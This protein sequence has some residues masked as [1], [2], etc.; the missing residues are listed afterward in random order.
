MTLHATEPIAK[1]GWTYLAILGGV[2]LFA[3]WADLWDVIVFALIIALGFSFYVFRNP[4][5]ILSEDDVL[6]IIAPIDGKVME[7]E[8][9]E[10]CTA[11]VLNVG[12]QDVHYFR[13]PMNCEMGKVTVVEGALLPLDRPNT[14]SLNA[15][16][17]YEFIAGSQKLIVQS[18][19]S[20]FSGSNHFYKQSGESMKA[21][22]RIGFFL[23]GKVVIK[24]PK[25]VQ[26]KVAVGDKVLGGESLLGF[27][28]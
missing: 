17:E 4:E 2:T 7:I 9:K 11:V 27:M 16:S 28:P 1:E 18:V 13:A 5:R 8:T 10:E 14:D 23:N 12:L 19:A 3:I 26:L 22:E 24:I 21:G 6:A 20:I 15:H 25:T